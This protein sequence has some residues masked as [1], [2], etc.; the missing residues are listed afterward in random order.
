MKKILAM[1]LVLAMVAGVL[2]G[3]GGSETKAPAA[4]GGNAPAAEGGETT[5]EVTKI[6]VAFPTWSGAPADTQKIQDAMNAISVPAIGVEAQLLVTDFAS[7]KQQMTLMMSGD[8][9][10]D[11]IITM[12]G[13][14]TPAIQN[15]Q[16]LDM[17]ENEVFQTYGQGIVEAVGMDYI[18][19]CRVGGVLYGLPN[20]RDMAV[21]K[22][23]YSIR[24]DLLESVGYVPTGAE[25]E[26]GTMEEINELFAKLHEKYP[27]MEVFRPVS[28]SLNQLTPYDYLGGD[29]FG[30][31]L[32]AANSLEVSNLYTSDEYL[33]YCQQMR[34]WYLAGYIS[35]DAATDTTA[36]GDLV[37]AGTLIAYNTGGKPGIKVQESGLCAH[38]MTIIQTGDNFMASNSVAGYPWVIPMNTVDPVASMKYLNLLYTNADMM[39]LIC[40][41]IEGTHYVQKEDGFLTFPE[42]VDAGTSGWNHSMNWMFP[43]QYILKVWEGNSAT[44]WPETKA[45]NDEAVHSKA[46]GF[47]FDTTNVMTEYTACSNVYTE[48]QKSLEFGL[49]DPVEGIAEMVK[50]MEAAGLQLIIDEKI[51]QLN[52]W[53]EVNGVK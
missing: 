11:V 46:L 41:G 1:L 36:V 45:F 37:K 12:G 8:E 42:G 47:A 38:E 19:A 20:N 29:T 26:T 39:N 16:L 23:C 30:V 17:E 48:Y 6:V 52:A 24:T 53:A 14:Y 4:E 9:Q 15:G 28:G 43:N 33:A 3:C 34:D 31:L 5:G 21:G 22:G 49:V 13:V 7:Y 27:D 2:A 51:A 44:L 18:N 50:K 25:I 10:L 32:D 35:P 40:W